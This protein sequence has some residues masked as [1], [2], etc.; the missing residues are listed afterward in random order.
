MDNNIYNKTIKVGELEIHYLTGGQG[1]PLIVIHGGGG[2]GARAWMKNIEALG[3]HYTVYVP[4]LPGF[5]RSQPLEGDYYIP[6]LVEFVEE[7]SH[8]LGLKS[9]YLMGHSLGGGI[10]L[11]YALKFPYK[12]TK[13]VLVSSLCLG[14]EIALWVRVLS[15]NVF[16]QAIGKLV[17]GILKAAKWAAGKLFATV[18]FVIPMSGFRLSLGRKITTLREQS[19]V[20]IHRLSEVM[21][22]TLVVWGADDPILPA[23]QA[24][25]AAEL[26]PDCQVKVFEDCGHSVYRDKLAEFSLLLIAFLG[27]KPLSN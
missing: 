1:D 16:Y 19:T 8:S 3:K 14:R 6:E 4:D 5:G 11:N 20:L 17:L 12:V 2:N 18:E 22:P 24:Y 23:R 7:F 25:A 27:S 9:F 13:L 10:A 21:V 26:I 15:S